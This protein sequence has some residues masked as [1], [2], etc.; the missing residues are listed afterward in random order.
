ML[1]FDIETEPLPQEQI[2]QHLP[3]FGAAACGLVPCEF[4]PASVNHGNTKDAAKRAAKIEEARAAHEAAQAEIPQRIAAAKSALLDGFWQT[5]TLNPATS[6]VLVV[7]YHNPHKNAFSFDFDDDDEARLITRF[8]KQYLTRRSKGESLVGVNIHD[9]DL[10]YLVRRSWMLGVD[11]PASVMDASFRYWDRIF[12]DLRKVWLL[13]QHSTSQKSSFDFIG[14]AM[15]TGGKPEGVSGGDF[16]KLWRTDR[17]AAEKYLVND[18]RQP[19][20]WAARMGIVK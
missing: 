20:E 16:H 11:V 15:G 10:P 19:G 7:G 18:L 4:D 12:V 17:A 1:V 3:T 9:F 6:R 8:W 5:A 2:E 14:K 13:G